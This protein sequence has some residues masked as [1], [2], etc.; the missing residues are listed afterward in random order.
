MKCSQFVKILL[1]L[2]IYSSF[3]SNAEQQIDQVRQDYL[4]A[5]HTAR[6]GSAAEYARYAAK[7]ADYPL[8]PYAEAIYLQNNLSLKNKQ[9][10]KALL[11]EYPHAPFSY[12]LRK[13]WLGYLAR[14]QLRQAFIE[15]YVD[16]GDVKLKCNH[17][18]W[19]LQYG[20]AKNDILP[21]VDDIWIAPFS[22][23]KECD[24]IFEVWKD[25]GYLTEEKALQRLIL[26]AKQKNY[27]L[28]PYLKRQLQP[29]Q[30]HLGSMWKLA[31]KRPANIAKSDFFLTYN[32]QEKQV[33]LYAINKLIFSM[34]EKVDNLWQELSGKFPLTE[35]DTVQFSKQLALAYAVSSH[36]SGLDWLLR[37][38]EEVVDESIKQWRLA[39]SLKNG[40]WQDT[41]NV[42]SS[43]PEYMQAD[44]AVAYWKARSLEQ[45]GDKRWADNTF[46]E[47]SERRDYYGFLA[48]NKMNKQ[49]NLRHVPIE[50]SEQEFYKLGR[51]RVLQR[52]YELY[53]LQR[54]TAARKEWNLLSEQLTDREKLA[55]AQ[56]AYNWGWY[57]RPIFMLAE[58]GYMNDVNLRF[59]L[60]YKDMLSAQ[61]K[62]NKVDPAFVFAIARRESSFM[63]DAYSTAGAAGL[64]QLKPSTASYVAKSR[65]KKRQLFKPERNAKLATNYLSYLMDKSKGNAILATAAY[66]AGFSRVKRWLPEQKMPADAW[67]ETIPYKETRNYVKAVMAYTEVYQALLEEE[68]NVFNGAAQLYIEPTL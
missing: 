55:A 29:E 51:N 14:R 46:S 57:D 43:L 5:E 19:Q 66:N 60:A 63:H 38:P 21:Q 53:K 28:L 7:I 49:V 44:E 58:V 50:I 64:M 36:E 3:Y 35:Q 34:P 48:A 37:V 67:V 54:Y 20:A 40:N 4:D 15:E 24:Y 65:V 68:S 27:R 59:P 41:L 42:T 45:L 10:I 47:L 11:S 8:A 12:K 61:A 30:K 9:R 52:A 22:Q 33:F 1:L 23:P 6:Y 17:L 2:C 31:V 62:S 26:A 16:I 32:E 25:A 18:T 39:Y 13:A 56:L